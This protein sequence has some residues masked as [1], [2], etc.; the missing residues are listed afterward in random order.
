MYDTIRILYKD[1][2]TL[3]FKGTEGGIRA[4][5]IFEGWS[6]VELDKYDIDAGEYDH[7]NIT[8]RIIVM[9]QG[10]S[11]QRTPSSPVSTC[12]IR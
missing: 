1:V 11:E 3:W 7:N 8:S 12:G 4:T 2:M 9:I 6:D 10:Y 5:E